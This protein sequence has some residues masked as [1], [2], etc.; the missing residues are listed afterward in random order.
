MEESKAQEDQK[1]QMPKSEEESSDNGSKTSAKNIPM[2]NNPMFMGIV[3]IV[4]IAVLAIAGYFLFFNSDSEK[5]YEKLDGFTVYEGEDFQIQYPEDWTFEEGFQISFYDQ[6][7]VDAGEYNPNLN[8]TTTSEEG[9]TSFSN[10]DC[11]DFTEAVSVQY[12][13]YMDNAEILSNEVVDTTYQKDACSI[14]VTGEF[15]DLK[16]EIKQVVFA[17]DGE[18]YIVTLTYEADT[19]AE[20]DTLEQMLDT[21]Q[22]IEKGE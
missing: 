11:D 16:S 12:D 19:K 13:L 5:E 10:S 15:L 22:I 9:A 3:A 20:L 21:F 7:Y 2:M 1:D 18:V 8:I 6:S 17:E 4:V 14:V